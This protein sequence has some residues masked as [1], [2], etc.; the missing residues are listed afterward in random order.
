MTIDLDRVVERLRRTEDLLN[1]TQALAQVGGWEWDVHN[2]TVYWTDVVYRIHDIEPNGPG[3]IPYEYISL[4]TACFD[5]K[6]R[7]VL[8]AAFEKCVD[9]GT[10]Y[11]LELPFTSTKG[12][13]MWVRTS[14]CRVHEEG[15]TLRVFG[16][17]MDI[18]EHKANEVALLRGEQRYRAI[19]QTAIEGFLLTDLEGRLLDVNEAYCEMSGYTREELLVMAV[20]DLDVCLGPEGVKERI[21]EIVDRGHARFET[22]HRAKDGTFFWLE[23]GARYLD[24]D[25]GYLVV[26]LRDLSGQRTAEEEQEKLQTQLIQAQKMESLGRLAG[27]VAHDFNNML[28]V[29]LGFAGIA[30]DRPELEPEVREALEEIIH[31]GHKSAS[32]TKQMLAFARKQTIAPQPLNLNIIVKSM[33]SMVERLI[34]ED[35]HLVWSPGWDLWTVE[36]DPAQVDQILV[37]LCVNARDAIAGV[38]RVTIETGNKVFDEE[39]CRYHSGFIPGE[40]VML[41]VCD[42]GV[43]MDEETKLKLFEP[44]FTTKDKEKGTGLGLATVYGIVKQN[45]GFI[46]V[47]S[48]PHNGTCFKIYLRR[49]LGEAAR[50]Q[51]TIPEGADLRGKETIL[52]VEDEPTIL[53][54]TRRMLEKLGY[55]VLD[56]GTPSEALDLGREHDGAIDLLLTD[57]V[58]PEMN[59]RDLS[60]RFRALRPETQHVFMSGYTANFIAHHGVLDPGVHF[61]QKPFSQQDLAIRLREA[62]DRK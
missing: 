48:E 44:F 49:H 53:R 47:Y 25:D 54:M 33:V 26:L 30:L 50:S 23:V 4:S 11:D 60:D 12:R 55:Q 59:G 45:N 34:G 17:L 19:L 39:Y 43:G 61:L 36:M 6:D 24:E 51:P 37:N 10:P 58:M 38:G 9:D 56:T 27:G 1:A 15:Q 14:A 52:L 16:T 40:F 18:T 62:L 42:D 7:P 41:S 57:V 2:E 5:A 35:I 8:K 20:P 3:P 46:N 28:N 13:R 22:R 29:I 21:G 31:A 32:V